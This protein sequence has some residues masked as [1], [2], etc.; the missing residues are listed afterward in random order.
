M[1]HIARTFLF[2]VCLSMWFLATISNRFCLIIR[3][4]HIIIS[5]QLHIYTRCTSTI[6]LIEILV[7][8]WTEWGIGNDTRNVPMFFFYFIWQ[9]LNHIYADAQCTHTLRIS[10]RNTSTSH[11]EY[12][13]CFVMC[14][15]FAVTFVRRF[16][17]R[18]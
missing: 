5:T 16:E 10:Q 7:I 13:I 15:Y 9:S 4:Q 12:V 2:F 18:W 17:W 11:T 14:F 8:I 1:H 6:N 3:I